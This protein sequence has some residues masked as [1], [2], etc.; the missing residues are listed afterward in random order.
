[1]EYQIPNKTNV[2]NDKIKLRF[3]KSINPFSFLTDIRGVQ[4]SLEIIIILANL[5]FRNSVPDSEIS[6]DESI[7]LYHHIPSIENII[8]L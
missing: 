7:N 8:E 2:V 1:M 3:K 4:L 5:E 6:I